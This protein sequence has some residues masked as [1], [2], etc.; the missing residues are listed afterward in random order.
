MRAPGPPAC[1]SGQ[2]AGASPRFPPQCATKE[3][4]TLEILHVVR[5][6]PRLCGVETSRW[7]LAALRE[8]LPWLAECHLGSI[9]RLLDRLEIRDKRGREYVHSPDPQYLAK[10]AYHDEVVETIH[11]S[12][13]ALVGLYL[14]E[15]TYY[16]QP[17]VARTW[18]AEGHEQ[19]RAERAHGTNTATRVLGALDLVDGR[20]HHHQSAHT[21]LPTFVRFYQD[22]VAAYPQAE[23]LTIFLDHWPVHFHPDLLVGLEPQLQPFPLRRP[24]SWPTEPTE[25]GRRRWGDSSPLPI[26]LVPLPTYASWLNPIEKLWRWLKADVLHMHRLAT[27][28]P[29]LRRLVVDFLA[30]FAHGSLDLLRYV[31]LAKAV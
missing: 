7:S 16:R 5:R 23:R 12:A 27:R 2:G 17:T 20:V 21:T 22:L 11:Q 28:L 19:G 25:L 29:D 4:A 24:P 31:G 14:D 15:L 30:D 18:E 13:D 9:S 6:D 3:E 8:Q 1:G 26:Q 10:L